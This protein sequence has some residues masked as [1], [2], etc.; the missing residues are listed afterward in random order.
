MKRFP[1]GI[2]LVSCFVILFQ[3]SSSA[4]PSYTFKN[5]VLISGTALQNGAKYRFSNVKTGIDALVTVKSQTGGVTLTEIDN[6]STGFDEAFQPFINVAKNSNGYV[7]FQVDFVN[8]GTSTANVQ[9]TVPITC[10]DVDGVGYSN[11]TLYEQDQV[12]Y[13]PGYYD[14]TMTGG[15]LQVTNSGGWV[16]IKNTSGFSYSG[17]DTAAKDVM[18][19]VVNKNFST[20]LLR[21]G[22][23]N[24]SNTE[25]EVRYRSVYFKTFNYGHPAPLPNRTMISLSGAKKQN[26]VELRGRLSAS[27]SFDKMIIERGATSGSFDYIGEMNIAETSS[28]EYPF[29]YIDAEPGN[30]VN[31]Y[32]IRLVNSA[33][34]HQ[35]ISN[36]LMVKMDNNHSSLDVINTVMQANSPVITIRNNEEQQADLQVADMSGRM[37]SNSKIRLNNGTNNINLSSFNTAKGF[38]VI[39]LRTSKETVSRRML[40]Q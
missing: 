7:E 5:A 17:I 11:G 3:L 35:E 38:F 25:S 34:K 37:I 26:S 21:I 6:N 13:I 1:A 19:T 40:V 14:F 4:Q 10:I 16:V 23:I 28:A 29:T 2:L 15:N 20:M 27:H 18:A 8:T 9:S 30:G 31:Y 39:V 32:R 22:G 24:T 12:Q 36:T 33:T